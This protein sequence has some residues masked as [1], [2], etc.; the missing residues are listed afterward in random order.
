MGPS[1][2]VTGGSVGS[3]N[4]V[5]SSGTINVTSN[6][7]SGRT[8]TLSTT[9]TVGGKIGVKNLEGVPVATK[10]LTVGTGALLK[11][12][13]DVNASITVA[14][15]TVSGKVTFPNGASYTGPAAAGGSG[16]G[17]TSIPDLPVMPL[18]NAFPD[19]GDTDIT[20]TRIINPG[21]YRNVN[22]GSN[23]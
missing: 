17:T 12:N 15:G 16:P 5:S 1:T 21:A 8:V 20:T 10:I 6:I 19:A 11:A 13:I 3:Y 23:Q 22:L 9:N 4:L 18:V 7:Y 14:G 2:F